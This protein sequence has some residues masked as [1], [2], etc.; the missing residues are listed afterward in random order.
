MQWLGTSKYIIF[1]IL[2]GFQDLWKLINIFIIKIY[3]NVH[4]SVSNDFS[5]FDGSRK[6]KVWRS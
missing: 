1:L 6:I 3:E 2:L 4:L 5:K